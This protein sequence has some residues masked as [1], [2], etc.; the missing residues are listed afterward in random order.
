MTKNGSVKQTAKEV[1]WLCDSKT[2]RA[3]LIIILRAFKCVRIRENDAPSQ[4][5]SISLSPVW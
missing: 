3:E 2:E 5:K 1:E 4:R